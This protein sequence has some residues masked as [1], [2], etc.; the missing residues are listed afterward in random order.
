MPGDIGEISYRNYEVQKSRV[1]QTTEKAINSLFENKVLSKAQ[2][3]KLLQMYLN[4]DISFGENGLTEEESKYFTADTFNEIEQNLANSGANKTQ[5]L[6][7]IQPGDTPEVIA[8]KLGLQGAE[9][10]NFANKIKANAINN[11]M[12]YSYGF[13]T[14]DM[15]TLPGD[16]S[17]KIEQMRINGEYIEDDTQLNQQ[18]LNVRRRRGS[19]SRQAPVREA[20]SVQKTG[21]ITKAKKIKLAAGKI[22]DS[23][24]TTPSAGNAMLNSITSE[25]VV[26]VLTLYNQK[27]GRNLAQDLYN[28]GDKKLVYIKNNICK[29]L[30]ARAK[31]LKLNGIYYGDYMKIKDIKTLMKWL[32]IART[33]VFE[34]E[35]NNNPALDKV[36]NNKKSVLKQKNSAYIK[37]DGQRLAADLYEQID[38][39]SDYRN[40]KK[41]LTKITRENAAYVVTEYK[42]TAKNKTHR[43]LVKDIDE[44]WNLDINDVKMYICKPLVAQAKILGLTG[45]YYG[46]YAKIDDIA[47][48]DKWVHN[49][50]ARIINAQNSYNNSKEKSIT[51]AKGAYKYKTITGSDLY[52]EAGITKCIEKYNSANKLVDKTFYYSDGKVVREYQDPKRGRVRELVKQGKTSKPAETKF[53]EPVPIKIGLPADASNNA[54]A[55]AK[56]LEDNKAVLMKELGI[57]N[58]TYDKLARL[59]MAIAKQETN[60]G[61]N[62][63]MYRKGKYRLG[64]FADSTQVGNATKLFHDYSYGPTQIKFE[65]QRRDSWIAE[66]FKKFN[67]KI[68]SQLY[69]MKNAAIATMIVLAQNNRILK[70]NKRYQNGMEAARGN[71][72]STE[73][74]EMKNGHLEKTYNTKPFVN[75]VTDEDALCYFWNGRGVEIID[76]TME[77][78]ALEYTRNIHQY[79]KDYTV[80]DVDKNARSK[81][82]AK[83]NSKKINRNFKPMD[84]NGPIGSIVFMPKMYTNIR[85]NTQNEIEILRTSLNKN[86]RINEASKKQ[87]LLCVQNGEIGFEFGLTAKEADSL[88]QKDVDRMLS[89]ISNIKTRITQADS[90]I[91]FSDGINSQ[92]AARLGTKYMELIRTEEKSFK[93]EYLNSKSPRVVTSAVPADSVLMTPM[94]NN[95]DLHLSRNRKGFKGKVAD[96]GVNRQNT[97]N[98][99]YVLA[100][101]GQKIARAMNSGGRCM[102]GFRQAML[103]AGVDAAKASDLKEGTPRATVGWFERHPDMFEEVKYINIGGGHSRQLNSS[104]LPNLPA[105]YI[106]VWI[107]DN[108]YKAEEPGHISITNG[109]GQAY[110]DETDN[111]DWGVYQGNRNSGKGEHGVFRVFRLTDKWTVA[112][113]KLKFQP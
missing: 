77:P 111:L 19:S 86:P 68:G 20:L 35:N 1:R 14:G 58:D 62:G 76:G 65:M 63:G 26:F 2:H 23:L 43:S 66:K 102:T 87:L 92:E 10:K 49:V 64:G 36:I 30:V 15:I 83:S 4:G 55:F 11:G 98:A 21:D 67:L 28:N 44:E 5:T 6:Y 107:P 88:T 32:E 108:R 93:K 80:K 78:E 8:E 72:V 84:N 85:A 41:M 16:Y 109:N 91:D 103:E 17:A 105:G 96:E 79:L 9:A 59:A 112:N 53:Y 90:S 70:G 52:K 33:K 25:N 50:S 39:F 110:S 74:W 22:V 82:I 13:Q 56:A 54:R 101:F 104:D 51:K 99:S 89:H 34:A 12:Y 24:K 57:D 37:K 113:G 48:L 95:F 97:T 38:G 31:A 47:T 3:D 60:F 27:T 7:V 106:V 18:Y 73:G 40:T 45:I 81:A 69:D 61:Q 100:T 94:N 42:N 75:K 29:P 46:D 71:V